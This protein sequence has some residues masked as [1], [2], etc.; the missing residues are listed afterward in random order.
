MAMPESGVD[1]Y[2]LSEQDEHVGLDSRLVP[3]VG[4]PPHPPAGDLSP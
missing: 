3:F 2:G 1:S 4:A